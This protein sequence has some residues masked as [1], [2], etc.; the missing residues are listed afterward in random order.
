[1]RFPWSV[2]SLPAN[3]PQTN[4]PQLGYGLGTIYFKKN[5]SSGFDEATVSHAVA[6]INAGY[7]HLDGAEGTPP[8]P[9]NTP[10][11]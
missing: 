3:P 6:A 11:H 4:P 8:P 9:H 2:L 1:M 7:T 5:A 10:P